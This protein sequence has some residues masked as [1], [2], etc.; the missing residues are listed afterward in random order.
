MLHDL[1]LWIIVI[2]IKNNSNICNN[3]TIKQK[4]AQSSFLWQF[5]LLFIFPV[6]LR[7]IC[8]IME[9]LFMSV[10]VCPRDTLCFVRLWRFTLLLMITTVLDMGRLSFQLLMRR[11]NIRVCLLSI[12][13]PVFLFLT[14]VF[15]KHTNW[16]GRERRRKK[17]SNFCPV[18]SFLA[19]VIPFVRL[20]HHFQR[21]GIHRVV[22][23]ASQE[24]IYNAIR[25]SGSWEGFIC[26]ANISHS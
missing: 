9:L 18:V 19:V 7:A 12:R 8:C 10:C 3:E 2:K 5:Y 21:I 15:S 14:F 1:F 25:L 16:G 11:K 13:S 23:H 20:I 17:I 4:W 26:W 24:M 6:E 22:W